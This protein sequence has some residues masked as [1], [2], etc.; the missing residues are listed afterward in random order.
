MCSSFQGH[1]KIIE[2]PFG[3]ENRE[4]LIMGEW[5]PTNSGKDDIP[6]KRLVCHE[7]FVWWVTIH[8]VHLLNIHPL[9]WSAMVTWKEAFAEYILSSEIKRAWQ[10]SWNTHFKLTP[11]IEWQSRTWEK[12]E[13][14]IHLILLAARLARMRCSAPSKAEVMSNS[15]LNDS[16]HHINEFIAVI[17]FYISHWDTDQ[18]INHAIKVLRTVAWIWVCVG[19]S[20]HWLVLHLCWYIFYDPKFHCKG[21]NLALKKLPR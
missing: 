7:K 8:L 13:S 12:M 2:E 1:L 10:I 11:H 6:R 3:P 21:R 5:W 14:I 17:W 20:I 15:N 16:K 18:H 9:L 19:L 4:K